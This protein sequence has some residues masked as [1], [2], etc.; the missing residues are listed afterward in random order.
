MSNANL[1][2][3][4]NIIWDWNGTLLDDLEVCVASINRLLNKRKLVPLNIPRYLEIFTFPVKEYYLSAGFDFTEETFETVAVE[5]MEHYLQLVRTTGLHAGVEKTLSYF[6]ESGRSQ[7]ILSA[8]E[9]DELLKLVRENRI[10]EYFTHIFGIDDHL[11]HGKLDLAMTAIEK[12]GFSREETCLIGDTLHDAEV[13]RELGIH[14]LLVA[15]GHQS[16]IRLKTSG[17]PVIRS[18]SEVEKSFM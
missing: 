16:E 7:I 17:Y 8:M 13:A 14:C 1:S 3:C 10:E 4:R 18:L 2:H 11:A 6:R 5:F 9:Q 15:D 12:T